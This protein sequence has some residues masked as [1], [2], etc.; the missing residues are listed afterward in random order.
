MSDWVSLRENMLSVVSD[1]KYLISSVIKYPIA[2]MSR[3]AIAIHGGAGTILPSA[4]TPEL[5]ASYKAAL[6]A[7]LDAGYTCLTSGGTSLE[8]VKAAVISLEDCILFNAGRGAVFA[9]D[10]SQEMDASIMEGQRLMAGAVSAVRNIR[11]PI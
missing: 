11:N 6:Q 10:G 1:T 2:R 3:Y 5:E 8:A 7:A 9:K 4:M